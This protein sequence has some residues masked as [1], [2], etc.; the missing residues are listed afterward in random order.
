[1]D[2]GNNIIPSCLG[3]C[4]FQDYNEK[5]TYSVFPEMNWKIICFNDSNEISGIMCMADG[6][7]I[8]PNPCQGKTK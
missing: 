1:M 6:K 4:I 8:L 3:Q 2:L 7:W 5:L